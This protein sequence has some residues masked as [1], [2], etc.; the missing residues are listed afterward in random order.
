MS[1]KQTVVVSIA[2]GVVCAFGMFGFAAGRSAAPAPVTLDRVAQPEEMTEEQIKEMMAQ[3]AQLAPQH[4][5]LHAMV[6]VWDA[7]M[8]FQMMPGEAPEVSRGTSTTTLILGGKF[9]KTDF[10]GQINMFGE[11]TAFTGYGL[12]GFDTVKGE[13]VSTWCD[14]LSTS[15]LVATGK[16]GEDPKRM[17]LSGSMPSPMGEVVMKNVYIIESDTKHVMEFW[18]SMPGDAEM[19][20]IGA[21]TYTKKG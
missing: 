17:E 9:L 8:S 21:I 15:L 14:S 16:P 13:Y 1:I 12:M 4:K 18:Q 20:K 10:E 19:S 7:E 6:G 5:E 3:Q 2:G 11:K